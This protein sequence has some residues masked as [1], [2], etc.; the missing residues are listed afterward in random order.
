[1][2]YGICILPIISEETSKYLIAY[3]RFTNKNYYITCVGIMFVAEI[4]SQFQNNW[5]ISNME[6]IDKYTRNL[7]H[8]KC[9]MYYYDIIQ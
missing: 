8:Q 2:F 4:Y 6:A 3:R 7:L 1:M 5:I 9:T